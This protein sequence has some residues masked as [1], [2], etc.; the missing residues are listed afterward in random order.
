MVFEGKSEENVMEAG[1]FL[2]E[3]MGII[4]E[5]KLEL[6]VENEK[7]MK[8][9]E[10]LSWE[11]RE[12]TEVL[13][14]YQG[15][16]GFSQEKGEIINKM[17]RKIE[18]LEDFIEE[19]KEKDGIPR[20]IEM[21]DLVENLEKKLMEKDEIIVNFSENSQKFCDIFYHNLLMFFL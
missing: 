11:I 3:Q 4:Q 19:I 17:Q 7:L 13:E 5:E 12:K 15:F 14:K 2:V 10:E 6:I 21:S 16:Y 9:I 18:E 20:L 8:K 1:E